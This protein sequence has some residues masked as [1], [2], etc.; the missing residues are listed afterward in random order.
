VKLAIYEMA[1]RAGMWDCDDTILCDCG[2]SWPVTYTD[3]DKRT[4][5]E[6]RQHAVCP[7]A[8]A[9]RDGAPIKGLTLADI[10]VGK[11]YDLPP[12]RPLE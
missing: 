4:I 10:A 3:Y 1:Q 8:T 11:T 9:R 12:G 6:L 7:Y 2:V 5:E